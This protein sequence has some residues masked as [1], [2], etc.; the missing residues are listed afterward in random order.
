MDN[1]TAKAI[2]IQSII[3]AILSV[4]VIFLGIDTYRQRKSLY[5]TNLVVNEIIKV[6]T[7]NWKSDERL[8]Q[9]ICD[10][11]RPLYHKDSVNTDRIHKLYKIVKVHE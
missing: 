7:E 3:I 2:T 1:T 6:D 9:T 11:L 10:K 8:F 4:S 5:E